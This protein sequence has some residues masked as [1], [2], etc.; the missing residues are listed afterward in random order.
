MYAEVNR[1]VHDKHLTETGKPQRQQNNKLSGKMDLLPSLT[2]EYTE[3]NANSPT[4]ITENKMSLH[5]S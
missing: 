2:A 4:T 5:M 1:M 3:Y